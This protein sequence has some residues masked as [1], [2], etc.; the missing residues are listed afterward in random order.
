MPLT[1]PDGDG[2]YTGSV[3]V[4]KFA[5]GPRPPDAQPISLPVRIGQLVQ[6]PFGPGELNVIKDFGLVKLDGDRTFAADVSFPENVGSNSTVTVT[7][8]LAIDGEVPEGRSIGVSTGIQDIAHPVFCTTAD[9]GGLPFCEDGETYSD[10]FEVPAEK[11]FSYEYIV[12]DYDFGGGV[13]TFAGDTQT[14][15]EDDT[16]SATY[17]PGGPGNT[18][19]IVEAVGVLE[20]PEATSY[21]YGTH[22]ITDEAGTDYALQSNLVDLDE[23]VEERVTV[24]GA[25]VSGFEDGQVEGGPPLMDVYTV[26]PAGGP[27]EDTVTVEFEL[28]VE[29]EPPTDAT[30]FG[31]LGYEPAPFQLVDP[32][33]DGVYTGNTPPDLVPA[34][35]TQPALIVQGTGTRESQVVGTSPG[36]PITTL[37]DFGEVTF[38]EDTTLSASVSFED[39]NGGSGS[40]GSG[41]ADGGI[42]GFLPS[43]GGGI[44]LTVL[45][46]GILLIGGGL[47]VRRLTR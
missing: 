19:K 18:V 34:G 13:E 39:G 21:Q 45:G 27:G 47:A 23:Y 32:D 8:E 15:N 44:A 25:L 16:V 28:A 26:E 10:T 7:F 12:F 3:D 41:S 17:E 43:T 46:A 2:L 33:G 40:D 22:A 36:D 24:Y 30:F 11:P 20:K 42:R 29:G 35:D 1:D 5:P 6:G 9:F 31:Y 37:K 14:F 4:P 38:E